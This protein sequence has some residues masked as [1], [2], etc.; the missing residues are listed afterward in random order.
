MPIAAA[1]GS[2]ARDRIAADLDAFRAL[3]PP[4][5]CY[6]RIVPVDEVITLRLHYREDDHLKR[7]VLDERQAAELDRLW[8]EL[9]FVSRDALA[10]VDVF[11][12]LLE[13]ASQ[14]AD[15]SVFEPLREPIQE[16]AAAFREALVD[17]EPRQL[18]AVVDFAALAYRRPLSPSEARELHEFYHALRA[19]ELN[20]DEA[21]RLTLAR[22]F[23][24]PAFLYRIE[25]AGPG[26]SLRRCRAGS[27]PTA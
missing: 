5:L 27:S 23:I 2:R 10:M 15:P 21:I 24:G 1:E 8:E 26:T 9:R 17:A 3:F 4:A 20:H 22:I 25:S 12:Q 18:D 11:Q 16:Q 7:L 13:Y 6:S 19:E 14:D